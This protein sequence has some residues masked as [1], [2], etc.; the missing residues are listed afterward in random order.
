MFLDVS[1]QLLGK[2]DN[3]LYNALVILDMIKI[4]KNAYVMMDLLMTDM[5]IVN[6]TVHNTQHMI[7]FLKSAFAMMVILKTN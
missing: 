7:P 2:M 5:E 1:I 3:V 6:Q 4:N